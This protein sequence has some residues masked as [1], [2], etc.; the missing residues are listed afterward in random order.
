MKKF[1]LVLGML[2]SGFMYSQE[3]TSTVIKDS[4]VDKVPQVMNPKAGSCASPDGPMNPTTV[5]PPSYAWLQANGYC[6]PNTYGQFPTVC[7]TFTPTSS[8]VS[9]NSGFSYNCNNVF[10]NNFNLYDNSCNLIGTGLNFAG[11]TPGVQYT[12]CMSGSTWGGGG[13][14][15]F[16]DF[17]PYYF[18]NT[19]LPVE[20]EDFT[21][22]NKGSYNHLYWVT[23]TEINNSHFIVERSR[24]GQYWEYLTTI[25]GSGTVNTPSFYEYNDYDYID[26][27]NYYRLIQI[28][29][30][31]EADTSKII[32]IST[33]PKPVIEK[34]IAYDTIGRIIP[35]PENYIGVIIYKYKN[36]FWYKVTRL[37]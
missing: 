18:N 5:N 34:P 6:N 28:D 36:G 32:S 27:V 15:G 24:G 7:W 29:Y 25:A 21:G 9:I 3:K 19:V 10:F 11:L 16:S 26:G 33:Q 13:C 31:S 37:R 22:S 1:I 30:N 2:V 23:A 12:W 4:I 20:L 17:C 8:S 35:D 14:T